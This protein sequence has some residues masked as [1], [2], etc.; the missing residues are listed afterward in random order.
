MADRRINPNN[1]TQEAV[2][3][4]VQRVGAALIG[5]A[6]A[7]PGS[8]LADDVRI[9]LRFS[10]TSTEGDRLKI[11]GRFH[12]L[13]GEN[14]QTNRRV[15]VQHKGSDG[16]RFLQQSDTTDDDGRY[17]LKVADKQGAYRVIAPAILLTS[18]ESDRSKVKRHKH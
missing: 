12:P 18:C 16:W 1:Q 4:R 8:A 6:L 13:S 2:V 10:H 14:C 11:A 9:T 7:I 17:R 5:I 15:F 3:K